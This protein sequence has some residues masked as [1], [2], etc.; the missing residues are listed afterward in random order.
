MEQI[1]IN[2]MLQ[3][4]KKYNAEKY[5]AEAAKLAR[6]DVLNVSRIVTESGQVRYTAVQKGP[7]DLKKDHLGLKEFHQ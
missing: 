7:H 3:E 5:L 4:A 2:T 1:E 6:A